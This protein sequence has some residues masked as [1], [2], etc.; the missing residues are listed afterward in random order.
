M[1]RLE[2]HT[3]YAGDEPLV[4]YEIWRDGRKT[5]ETPHK[6]QARL[7]APFSFEEA[8][9]DRSAHRY[10]VVAVDGAGKTAGTG[11]LELVAM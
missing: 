8:L 10:R 6:P 2:W 11:D 5:A 9:G 3:A 4:R 1:A 7:K